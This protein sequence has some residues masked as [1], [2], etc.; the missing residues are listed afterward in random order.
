M[1]RNT[2]VSL[3]EHFDQFISSQLDSGRY[4]SASEVI[5][6]ALRLLE[7]SEHQ[8]ELLRNALIAGERS[9]AAGYDMQ[10]LIDELDSQQP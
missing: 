10:A 5:R 9:G 8:L 2:S 3:G 7:S 6:A 1:A 4:G